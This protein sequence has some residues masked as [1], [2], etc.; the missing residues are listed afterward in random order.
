MAFY[1]GQYGAPLKSLD[2]SPITQGA[3][4]QA[5]MFQNLGQQFGN[6]ISKWF[7]KKEET[8]MVESM[9]ENPIALQ[10]VY[11]DQ[12]TV[13]TD[14]KERIK[15]I[16]GIVRASGGPEAFIARM[17]NAELK[18]QNKQLSETTLSLKTQQLEA[19]RIAMAERAKQIEATDA[20]NRWAFTPQPGQ[21]TTKG[22]ELEAGLGR[23]A[24]SDVPGTAEYQALEASEPM[25]ARPNVG[26]AALQSRME[27]ERG[28][29]QAPA[30][31][32]SNPFLQS[33]TEADLSPGAMKKAYEFARQK[34]AAEQAAESARLTATSAGLDIGKK[35]V[36]LA[37]LI[38]EAVNKL[39][40]QG[41]MDFKLDEVR[42]IHMTY[43]QFIKALD[44]GKED[45]ISANVAR[46]K[47]A[48]LLQPTGILT[49]SDISRIGESGA[50]LDRIDQ[51]F[52]DAGG[53]LTEANYT[54]M[55]KAANSLLA[56][57]QTT[58]EPAIS[59]IAKAVANTYGDLNVTP[60]YVLEHS[61]LKEY[62]EFPWETQA[63][64]WNPGGGGSDLPTTED[65]SHT[66]YP[67]I[68]LE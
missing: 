2:T 16:R 26:A 3:A 63:R 42:D 6:V 68:K 44:A 32:S 27:Q 54:Q 10:V 20:F 55:L 48:R 23:F 34:V 57:A 22:R 56:T 8:K 59:S 52:A 33:A 67:P 39:T 30:A 50:L 41:I 24:P 14:Q 47:L 62:M 49:D 46:D 36:D 43:D 4:I 61:M 53:E 12:G 5:Q 25:G 13:P 29:A 1:T 17:E 9:A 51:L 11:G 58:V 19:N 38:P 35:R 65:G 21:L 60:K 15:D 7:D 64:G 28:P 66:I 18:T 31:M 37:K 45:S 40:R